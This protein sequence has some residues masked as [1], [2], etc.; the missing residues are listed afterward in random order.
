MSTLTEAP[1]SETGATQASTSHSD[2]QDRKTRAEKALKEREEQAKAQKS[3][4][5]HDIGRSKAALDSAEAGVDLM[6]FY[7]DAV[8]D[9]LVSSVFW[10]VVL[11]SLTLHILL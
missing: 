10:P 8:R 11:S 1:P 7:V 9:P 2:K 5:E 6:S 3:R 4:V